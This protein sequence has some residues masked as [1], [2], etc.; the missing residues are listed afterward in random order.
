MTKGFHST[1]IQISYTIRMAHT[2]EIAHVLLAPKEVG[3]DRDENR[4]ELMMKTY[5]WLNMSLQQQY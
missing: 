5:Y 1:L 3:Q 2:S 4:Y